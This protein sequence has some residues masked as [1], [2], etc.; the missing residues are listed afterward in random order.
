MID[1]R[2]LTD[3]PRIFPCVTIHKRVSNKNPREPLPKGAPEKGQE[4]KRERRMKQEEKTRKKIKNEETDARL[5]TTVASFPEKYPTRGRPLSYQRVVQGIPRASSR[6][7][8][9]FICRN[10]VGDCSPQC[11]FDQMRAMMQHTTRCLVLYSLKE[12]LTGSPL[13]LRGI[14]HC[15]NTHRQAIRWSP[16]RWGSI[17]R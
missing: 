16:R 4:P 2:I 15:P 11:N 17:S 6:I 1:C 5:R 8:F 14:T 9:D 12:A 3:P 7:C 13:T 10:H